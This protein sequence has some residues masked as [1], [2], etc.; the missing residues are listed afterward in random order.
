MPDLI[1][2]QIE[3]DIV[4][5]KAVKIIDGDTFLLKV[6]GASSANSEQYDA[7]EKVRVVSISSEVEGAL[8][9]GES[10]PE[11]DEGDAALNDPSLADLAGGEELLGTA[12]ESSLEAASV[13]PTEYNRVRTKEDL[14]ARIKNRSVDC[15]VQTRDE[16][17]RLVCDVIVL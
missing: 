1:R 11:G 14:A 8:P 4:R 9:E 3:H 5:G 6:E 17:G 12:E 16:N 2:T 13:N 10:S 7:V 15:V